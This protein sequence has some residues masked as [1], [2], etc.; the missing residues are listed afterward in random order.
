MAILVWLVMYLVARTVFKN[1]L[2][3]KFATFNFV[4]Q[5][6]YWI[7]KTLFYY[8]QQLNSRL[9]TLFTHSWKY[10]LFST[11]L[12]EISKTLHT[13]F[14]KE[15]KKYNTSPV[16]N[17]RVDLNL[18]FSL[19]IASAFCNYSRKNL[20]IMKLVLILLNSFVD[21]RSS[22]GNLFF[23]DQFDNHPW[24]HPDLGINTR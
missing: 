22:T 16:S 4:L 19:L 20:D 1:N 6:S 5:I 15:E 18:K 17:E 23:T 14:S 7:T 11:C 2:K 13:V 24:E 8:G 3:N 12:S 10:R 9:R 21:K